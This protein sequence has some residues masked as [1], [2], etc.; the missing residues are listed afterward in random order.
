MRLEN[1]RQFLFSCEAGW[2]CRCKIALGVWGC[3]AKCTSEYSRETCVRPYRKVQVCSRDNV[4]VTA[5]QK[6]VVI[7]H[8]SGCIAKCTSACSRDNTS[9]NARLQSWQ[10]MSAAASQSV[11]LHTFVTTHCKM[12]VCS[13]D[14]TCLRLH[15]KVCVCIQ[16]WQHTSAASN[17]FLGLLS[18]H[19]L[20]PGIYGTVAAADW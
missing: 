11:P 3:I 8:V 1:E 20:Q 16:S 6:A 4:S 13:R 12:H 19:G 9:Q 14:N 10:H 5:L 2:Y 17:E 18:R 7:T 15:R